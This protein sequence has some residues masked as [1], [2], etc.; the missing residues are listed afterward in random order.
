MYEKTN[1][2]ALAVLTGGLGGALGG[3]ASTKKSVWTGASVGATT[4]ALT[5][6]L[7]SPRG[8]KRRGRGEAAAATKGLLLGAAVGATGAYTIHHLLKE[9]D[10]RIQRETLRK[11][12]KFKAALSPQG[13]GE[14]LQDFKLSTPDVHKECFDWEVRG[15]R[16]IQNHCVWTIQEPSFWVPSKELINE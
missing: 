11:F 16:L 5:G 2:H 13:E 8:S 4:G 1:S 6:V 3:C 9:R 15:Q 12:D 10:E 14:S 7:L